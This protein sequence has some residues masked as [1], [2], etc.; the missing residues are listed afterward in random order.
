MS[1]DF[2]SRFFVAINWEWILRPS[3]EPEN[4]RTVYYYSARTTIIL[5]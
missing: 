4:T 5:P 1:G 2:Y 3:Q